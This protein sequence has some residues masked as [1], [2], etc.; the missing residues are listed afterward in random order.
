MWH[1]FKKIFTI[2]LSSLYSPMYV[3]TH[4]AVIETLVSYLPLDIKINGCLYIWLWIPSW[5]VASGCGILFC[6]CG[7]VFH[8]YFVLLFKSMNDK[9]ISFSVSLGWLVYLARPIGGLFST[10]YHMHL[11]QSLKLFFKFHLL[12]AGNAH[13][14]CAVTHHWPCVVWY[15]FTKQVCWSYNFIH[16]HFCGIQLGGSTRS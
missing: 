13:S 16:D 14:C 2:T 7:F 4:W 6:V 8:F 9:E 3:F 12:Y 10:I 5:M 15:W 1:F 11:I